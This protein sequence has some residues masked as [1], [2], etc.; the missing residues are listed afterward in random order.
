MTAFFLISKPYLETSLFGQGL[1][2]TW[3]DFFFFYSK[4]PLKNWGL[5]FLLS[6]YAH[7][8][9]KH[10]LVNASLYLLISGFCEKEFGSM[11]TLFFTLVL[12]I[13]TLISTC[14][15]QLILN[16]ENIQIYYGSSAAVVGLISLYLFYK[17][18]IIVALVIFVILI[19]K[20]S[21]ELSL[22]SLFEPH[23]IS[24]LIGATL[25][26]ALFFIRP[27]KTIVE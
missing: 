22:Y 26:L 12:H 2:K 18:K 6:F 20:S 17:N 24:Y 14:F 13:M 23:V 25:A 7:I 27:P 15:Y 9:L 4:L 8:G 21:K 3:V 11:K 5:S 1:D 16:Y 19:W 10:F